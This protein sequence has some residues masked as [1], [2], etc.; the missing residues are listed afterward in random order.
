MITV[1]R[2]LAQVFVPNGSQVNTQ[3]LVRQ[4]GLA[5]VRFTPLH[6]YASMPT[7]A[8]MVLTGRQTWHSREQAHNLSTVLRSFVEVW[9]YRYRQPHLI[10]KTPGSRPVPDHI[11][12]A[13]LTNAPHAREQILLG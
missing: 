1:P 8:V 4:L 10:H 9:V 3:R 5:V 2:Y 13:D 11:V 12:Y 6:R 7:V